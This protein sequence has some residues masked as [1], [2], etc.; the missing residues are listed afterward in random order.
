MPTYA[1]KCGC[2]FEF[3]TFYKSLPSERLQKGAPCPNCN[4]TATRD[5]SKDTFYAVGGQQGGIERDM[6][7]AMRKDQDGRPIFTDVNGKTREVRNSKDVDFWAKNNALGR[8]RLMEYKN[9]ITGERGWTPIRTGGL[10]LDPQTGE[11]MDKGSIVRDS[12]QLVPL[13]GDA[14]QPSES[15]SGIPMK[16]GVLARNPSTLSTGIPDPETGKPITIGDCWG[17][18]NGLKQFL[19]NTASLKELGKPL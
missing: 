7:F 13:G 19:P 4:G 12:E 1:Y 9:P 10:H 2:E 11:P 15:R 14:P 6:A 16:N 3:E 18:A 8:P 5:V 17:D